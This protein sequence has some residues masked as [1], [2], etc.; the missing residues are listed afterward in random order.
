MTNFELVKQSLKNIKDKYFTCHVYASSGGA[1]GDGWDGDTDIELTAP[2]ILFLLKDRIADNSVL[3]GLEM[4][5]P[6]IEKMLSEEAKAG[7]WPDGGA[8][9]YVNEV[10]PDE[11]EWLA[12]ILEELDPED[13]QSVDDVRVELQSVADGKYTFHFSI[14]A[15]GYMFDEDVVDEVELTAEEALGL[16]YGQFYMPEVFEGICDDMFD[17]DLINDKYDEMGVV[18]D[19]VHFTYWGKCESLEFFLDAW[20]YI[21][22]HI[23]SG[24]ISETELPLWLEYFND[25]ENYDC[26]IEY[27]YSYL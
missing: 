10:I 4:E 11:L 1:C 26:S 7:A 18:D 8:K 16:L 2:Q 19:Y 27:W 6:N 14:S 13:E 5:D 22:D 3:Q 17:E 20:A 25:P 23:L 12:D 9:A 21:I 15:D 24:D